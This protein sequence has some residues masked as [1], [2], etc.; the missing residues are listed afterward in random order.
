MPD[1]IGTVQAELD[2]A[3]GRL[4]T[5]GFDQPRR[6]ALRVWAALSGTGPGEVW[7]DQGSLAPAEQATRFHEAVGRLIAGEPIQYVIGWTGFRRLVLCCDRRALIPRPETEGLV[8]LA[9]ALAPKGRA[10]DLGTGT[11]CLALALADEGQYASVTAVDRSPDALA[12]ARHNGSRTGLAVRWL[13]GDWCRPVEGE[14]FDLVVSNPP[15]ITGAELEGL[16]PGVREW[17]PRVAL[18]GG[19]DGLSEVTRL[20]R[21]VP[22]VLGPGGWLL[23][24]LDSTRARASAGLA[25]DLGWKTATVHDDLFG[26]PRYLVARRESNDA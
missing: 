23:M 25:H 8:D 17:E 24:E 7:Q 21:D 12:L 3:S 14:Q 1:L 20:L 5:A 16:E 19:P 22:R 10:L 13:E 4:A 6:E 2:A 11:G 15:Y 26:R 18:D 9:L